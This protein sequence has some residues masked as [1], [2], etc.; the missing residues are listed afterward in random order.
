VFLSGRAE[1][2]GDSAKSFT[3]KC[4]LESLY[5]RD[6][7]FKASGEVV[8]TN[9]E[10]TANGF[11]LEYKDIKAVLPVLQLSRTESYARVNGNIQG[12]VLNKWLESDFELNAGFNDIDSWLET[13][14]AL[15][16]VNGT[17]KAD[18]ILYGYEDRDP[19]IFAFENDNG[20]VAVSG[21]PKNMLKFE[22][23]KEGNFLTSLSSP[24][25]IRTTI[26]GVYK[27]GNID[28]RCADFYMD[29]SS[30]WE[31]VPDSPDFAIAGG[32]VTGK[33]D[34]RGPILDPEF[35]GTARGTSLRF[36]VPNYIGQ[37]IKP[38]PFD[39]VLEGSELVFGPV[40]VT[41]GNGG[42][43]ISG[44]LRFENWVPDTVGLEITVPRG[45]PIPYGFN[46]TGFVAKGDVSGKIDILRENDIVE[47][48]GGLYTNNTELGV[49]MDEVMGWKEKEKPKGGPTIVNLTV[50]T[51]P[52]VEFIWPNT[53]APIL[54]ANL[55]IGTVVSVFADSMT[56]QY[57]INSD[58]TIRSGELYYFD[59]GFYIRQGNLVFRET[60]QQ[61]DP[62]ISARAEIRE[63]TDSGPVTI[64]MIIN[65]EPLLGFVPRFEA[66][67]T[68]TQLEIY[69]LLGHSMYAINGNEGGDTAGRVLLSSTTD[70]ISQFLANTELGQITGVRQ[71]ER[72]VRN[73]LNLDMFSVRTKILQNAVVTGA[74]GGSGQA[75]A[76]DRS[77]RMG[78][79]F[80]N[81]TVYLGKYIGQDMF[82]QGMVAMRY[83]ENS[84]TMGGLRFEPDI[85]IEFTTPL[86][87]IRWDFY[88]YNSP[89]NWWIN[90][91]SITLI[92]SKSF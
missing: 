15:A 66:S 10:F 8:F 13:G 86:F 39:A 79:Y 17:F 60:E 89:E 84:L 67:P 77:S 24:L 51:G 68:L 85:G 82:I 19:F 14:Q 40:P 71:F 9:D 91:N 16:S 11:K 80:D 21:G 61:F 64:S 54:R 88:P 73:V 56:E 49:S 69:S 74:F 75:S 36:L 34:I 29:L 12:V 76:V 62:R 27:N 50:T 57:I 63:R 43:T 25:P 70:I 4:D 72:I 2:N 53:S 33:V 26:V 44:W 20:A 30:I 47:I 5:F 41:V 48:S 31:F 46:I 58:I 18:K 65:N 7:A 45:T 32:Y 3:A 87:N 90:D 59:R 23:D 28:A 22:M 1:V 83:D 42:G 78:N 6:N 92:W 81:T 35:F 38:V 55:E 37:D 52:V